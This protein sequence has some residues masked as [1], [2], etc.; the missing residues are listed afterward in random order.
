MWLPGSVPRRLSALLVCLLPLFLTAAHP[1]SLAPGA[2]VGLAGTP[3]LWIADTQGVLH[4]GGDTRA[5][6]GKH[7]NWND[8]RDVSLAELQT[9][10]LGDPW[11]SAGLLKDGAPI[12]QVKWESTWVQ[13]KLLHIQ[14]IKDVELFGIN[15][16]NYGRFV[17]D[18]ATWE[19]RYGLDA[20]PLER[21][22]LASAV[23]AGI[24][25]TLNVVSGPGP[26]SPSTPPVVAPAPAV[27]TITLPA[28]GD[29][30]PNRS[31]YSRSDWR[32]WTDE[33]GDCQ[34]ARHEVLLAEA[35]VPV[36][37]STA[38]QCWVVSGQWT[39]LY[40]GTVV[41]QASSLDIDHLVPLKHAHDSGGW[42]WSAARKREYAN[43]LTPADHL[44]AVTARAN[45]Q[46]G[47]RGPAEWKPADRSSWCRYARSWSQV[48][49]TWGLTST[50]TE[51]TALREMLGTCPGGDS[52][53]VVTAPAP[54]TAATPT[55]VP[56]PTATPRP[57]PTAIP[58]RTYR[59]CTELRRD[60]P[61]GVRRN[62]PAYQSRMDRDNDGWAC[63]R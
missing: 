56:Q 34:D 35:Q 53:P 62:H 6:A 43:A 18:K 11:L 60:Y 33:D 14:S 15:G 42:R 5:L 47:A 44:I 25:L 41:T 37:F 26:A 27:T 51:L 46:K 29:P 13:P 7:V 61:N 19:Q 21:Q 10:P 1:A 24:T 48:K 36:T 57:R 23:P 16:S 39:G 59:N 40:T 45:R 32:H 2:V 30:D 31:P 12:Y 54:V 52:V 9:Y 22:P 55:A 49:V 28:L 20:A 4:W 50:A 58:N 63:E 8:R 3:H 17:L 38:R